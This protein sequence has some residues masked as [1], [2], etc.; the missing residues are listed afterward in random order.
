MQ[1]GGSL[2]VLGVHLVPVS[3]VHDVRCSCD[4]FAL[5]ALDNSQPMQDRPVSFLARAL[6]S[7][8]P[9]ICPKSYKSNRAIPEETL[10]CNQC[11]VWK[12]R[13]Q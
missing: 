4:C 1:G 3:D 7:A 8:K 5:S 6:G 10:Q 2:F 9:L 12:K 11:S 13:L